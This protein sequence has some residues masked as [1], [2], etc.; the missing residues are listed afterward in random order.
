M[1]E[2]EDDLC[3]ML[4]LY[5]NHIRD[6]YKF[7]KIKNPMIELLFKTTYEICEHNLSNESNER[8]AVLISEL[9][10]FVTGELNIYDLNEYAATNEDKYLAK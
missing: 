5:I 9:R 8:N 3:E 10:S 6:I 2:K 4:D 1:T 7:C